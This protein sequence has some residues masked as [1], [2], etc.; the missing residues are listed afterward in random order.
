MKRR[1]LIKTLGA[2][3][4]SAA[5]ITKLDLSKINTQTYLSPGM[6]SVPGPGRKI[7]A[8][9]AGAGARGNVY[10]DY[11]LTYP[12]ELD[13]VGVAEPIPFRREKYSEK[14]AIPESSQFVT[15][16][17]IFERPKFAD[18]VI[19]TTPDDLHY[20]PAMQAMA[21]GYDLLLEK[22]IAQSWRECREILE[23]QK[24]YDRIVAVCHVLRYAPYYQKVKELI[25]SDHFGRVTSVQHFEPIQ[26]IHMAHSFVRGNWRNSRETNPSILA[27][28]CHDMD[29]LRWWIDKRCT[30]IS[31]FGHLTWFKAENA[32]EGSTARCLDGCAIERECPYSAKRIYYDRREWIYVFDLPEGEPQRG[33]TIIKFL[34]EGPYGRCVY[35]CDNDV[36]EHQVCAM[37]FED[38]ITA[39]FQMEAFTN[40]H[41]RKT[42]IMGSMG[43]LV[44]DGEEMVVADFRTG[45]VEHWDVADHGAAQSGHGGGDWRLVRDFL[46]AVDVHDVS[47][48]T[49]NLDASMDS[50]L[51][52]FEAEESRLSMKT[53]Q[54][55]YP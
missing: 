10:G 1:D 25:Q 12:D 42:R 44:G 53:R 31:S 16:E 8:V 18:V 20:G 29:I 22:P 3:G 48:L 7:T 13:I 54:I 34:K 32:P 51:M 35:R 24:K 45:E 39:T 27:K 41:G 2:G 6:P 46:R 40:Y 26:H 14:H 50:H 19:I 49:S 47:F 43:D 17:H 11:A 21:L 15:W 28:S 55:A 52:C 4:I 33:E 38:E 5:W 23:Q 9:V 36:M 30:H 37:L